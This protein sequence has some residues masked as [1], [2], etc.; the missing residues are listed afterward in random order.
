MIGALGKGEMSSTQGGNPAPA[1]RCVRV[2]DIM[3]REKL[4]DNAL[5]MGAIMKARL[6]EIKENCPYVGDV[7]G[8]AW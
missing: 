5:R 2:I 1:R 3:Q 8:R 7:R 6:L 4:D